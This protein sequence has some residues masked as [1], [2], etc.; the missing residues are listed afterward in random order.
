MFN[1]SVLHVW[2]K[3]LD[4]ITL[5]VQLISTSFS[6]SNLLDGITLYVQIICYSYLVQIFSIE[7]HSMFNFSVLHFW[8]KTFLWNLP[9][10]SICQYFMSGSKLWDGITLYGQVVNTSCLV[11]NFWMESPC[12]FTLSVLHVRFKTFGW[13]HPICSACLFHIWFKK[14]GLNH[15]VC[16]T[17]LFFMSDSKLLDGIFLYVKFVS[18]SCLAQNFYIESH[19][20]F[21]LSVLHDWLTNCCIEPPCI[22]N[23]S[24]F[25]IWFKTWMESHYV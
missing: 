25:H 20:M 15:L 18:T 13:K 23:L 22:F 17:C 9:V 12:M 7:S 8:F 14:F 2:F 16:S 5:Y 3:I 24:V 11:R 1:L 19:H 6:C 4:G 21:N 10:C